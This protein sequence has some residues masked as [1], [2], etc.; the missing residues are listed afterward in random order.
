M[1]R[2]RGEPSP[3][4]HRSRGGPAHP[5]GRLGPPGGRG[6]GSGR[7]HGGGRAHLVDLSQRLGG[8]GV[9]VLGDHVASHVLVT[10]AGNA[11]RVL[12]GLLTDVHRA[13]GDGDV[14]RTLQKCTILYYSIDMLL[15]NCLSGCFY[16]NIT[17]YLLLLI[18]K[19]EP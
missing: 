11:D 6:C 13:P 8:Q 18:L 9:G 10:W 14:V 4:P 12:T 1:S 19:S 17:Y 15:K 16:D 2:C 7:R 3:C 5:P